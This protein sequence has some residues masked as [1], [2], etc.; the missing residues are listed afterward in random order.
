[1]NIAIFTDTYFPEING[2]STS[3]FTLSSELRKDGHSVHIFTVSEPR[4]ALKDMNEDI[5]VHRFPASHSS[6]SNHIV[7][8]LRFRFV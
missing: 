6:F 7:R 1:M 4:S 3:V 2:V 8:Q 5:Y